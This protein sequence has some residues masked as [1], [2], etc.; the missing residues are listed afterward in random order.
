MADADLL[1][2]F[3]DLA[4][5]SGLDQ[6]IHLEDSQQQ[7]VLREIC[8]LLDGY[9]LGAELIFGTARAIEGKVYTPEAATRSLAE[10]RDELR[11]TQ[12]AGIS[13]VLHV[14]YQ[15]LSAPAGLLLSDLAAF[16]LPLSR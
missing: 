9:P 8:T 15:P 11:E 10:V 7:T 13:A 14:G 1:R 16:Q 6:R 12:L 4:S 3:T 5:A 2:L